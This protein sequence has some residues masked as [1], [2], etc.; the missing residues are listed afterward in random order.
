MNY[1]DIIK[2]IKNDKK[3]KGIKII[4]NDESYSFY[5]KNVIYNIYQKSFEEGLIRCIDSF[6]DCKSLK[7]EPIYDL[8]DYLY[9]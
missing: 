4:Y 8:E 1:N 2:K 7:Y 5:T 3:I 9:Y 6:V